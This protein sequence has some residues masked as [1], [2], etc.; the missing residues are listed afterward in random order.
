MRQSRKPSGPVAQEMRCKLAALTPAS[1]WDYHGCHVQLQPLIVR[2]AAQVQQICQKIFGPYG[3]YGPPCCTYAEHGLY[4]NPP[5][6]WI[7]E[8]RRGSLETGYPWHLWHVL[9]TVAFGSSRS[10]L[11]ALPRGLLIDGLLVA[12]EDANQT[13]ELSLSL[14]G[15]AVSIFLLLVPKTDTNVEF[16]CYFML[17][18]F[19]AALESLVK[20]FIK[21]FRIN[22]DSV[23]PIYY[24]KGLIITFD[25]TFSAQGNISVHLW[26]CFSW[27]SHPFLRS[28][29][30]QWQFAFKC[31][32]VLTD[33][34]NSSQGTNLTAICSK[35]QCCTHQPTQ[36]RLFRF[37]FLAHR[38]NSLSTR[39]RLQN[40]FTVHP[41]LVISASTR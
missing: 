18:R 34:N 15:I 7:K 25:A 16:L 28:P 14:R 27:G 10:S 11:D 23:T 20:L 26:L 31:S 9:D 21:S 41:V 36:I 22:E 35:S 2:F 30:R 29:Q 12:R 39:Y 4:S 19:I 1:R 6:W 24:E 37:L 5:A 40:H 13:A 33:R 32:W 38:H 8:G 17:S 3:A